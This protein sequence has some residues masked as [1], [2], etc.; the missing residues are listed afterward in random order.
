M[1]Y[2]ATTEGRMR[3]IAYAVLL[4][5]P[6]MPA[7]AATIVV[8]A[9]GSI[10]AAIDAAAPGD[11]LSVAAGEFNEDLDFRGKAVAVIGSGPDTIVRG[12]GGGPVVTFAAGE[13]PASVLDSVTVTGGVAARGGGIRIAGA[14]PTVRRSIIVGNRAVARGSGVYL[15]AST[16]ALFN[17]LIVY[18]GTAGGDPHGV[19]IE[20]ASPLIVNN[21]IARGDS[22]GLIVRGASSPLIANNVI[23]YNGAVIE[24]E[25]RGRGIC[26]FSGGQARIRYN[27]FHKNRVA[28]LLTDGRDFRRMRGAQRQIAPPRLEGNLDGSPLPRR[29]RRDL[30]AVALPGDFLPSTT[31]RAR[32]IDAGDP[33]PAYNDLDGTRNDAGFTGGPYAP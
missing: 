24:G 9:G 1:L 8:G 16:A 13:G 6:A 17:N 32:A 26:D 29:P 14:S 30:D 10:Q 33:D 23:A 12:T 27:V 7:T 31:G 21:T 11:V 3:A 5:L 25:R 20:N 22:N 18:N 2:Y 19:E 28:A 15:E 4:S